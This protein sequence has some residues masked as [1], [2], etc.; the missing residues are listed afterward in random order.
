MAPP[1]IDITKKEEAILL[2]SPN[3]FMPN[4]KMVGNMIDIKK[5]TASKEY[6]A[7]LPELTKATVSNRMV[8][9]AYRLNSFAGLIYRIKN[10]PAKRPS[11]KP[12]IA[13]KPHK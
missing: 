8:I 1:T 9:P 13:I 7:I 5:G 3:P 12:T 2:S 11:I 4:A 10:V 6:T